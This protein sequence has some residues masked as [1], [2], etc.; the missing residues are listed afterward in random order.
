MKNRFKI[1]ITC[2]VCIYANNISFAQFSKTEFDEL[3][4]R[5]DSTQKMQVKTGNVTKD[6][7]AIEKQKI[8]SVDTKKQ[9]VSNPNY[10]PVDTSHLENL[11]TQPIIKGST[12]K[13][14]TT[15]EKEK[16]Q[17]KIVNTP[18]PEKTEIKSKEIAK[19]KETEKPKVENKKP[20]SDEDF[21]THPIVKGKKYTEEKSSSP[22]AKKFVLDTTK[23]ARNFTFEGNPVINNNASYNRRNEPMPKTKEQIDDEIP[24]NRKPNNTN[25]YKSNPAVTETYA[26]YTKEADSI[27]AANKRVLDSVMR[28][29]KIK[30]P[31]IINP[32]DYI[33]IYVSGGGTVT[34]NDSKLYEHIAI[35]QTGVVQ[36][37]YKTKSEGVQRTEKKISKDELT[38]LA[39]YIVDMD[40]FD[41]EKEYD[42]GDNDAACNER[43]KRSPQAVPLDVAVTVGERKN[44]THVSFYAPRTDKNWVNYPANLEKIMNA[45]Y[46]IVER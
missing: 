25:V 18:T 10:K 33:D 6:M 24:V 35:S 14:K 16:V 23:D 41:L 15:K 2:I 27:H 12:V 38:K 39:Q 9:N 28:T 40:F 36:R 29:L 22:P 1:I 32:Q 11:S 19:Q 3:W 34:S 44:K 17:E 13:S 21:S 7:N 26:L 45:I 4:N 43:L 37:E 8:E 5:A 30:V 31:V 42:C 20:F 46:A